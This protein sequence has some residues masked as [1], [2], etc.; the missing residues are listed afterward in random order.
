[1]KTSQ[2][3]FERGDHKWI[4]VA[5]DPAKPNYLIDTNEFVIRS[6]NEALLMDPGGTEIFPAVFSA[7]SHVM[8]PT[9]IKLLFASHQDPDIIS[10]L[11]LWIDFQPEIVCHLSWLWS[12]FVPHFGG[13]NETFAMIPDVGK[14]F[15]M[16]NIELEC[17][18][19]HYLHSSGNFH[20]YDKQAKILFSGDIGA[21]LLPADETNFVVTDFDKHIELARGFHQR[22]MGS[23]E[24]KNEWC[25]RVSN[26]DIDMMCPQHGAIYQGADVERFINWFADLP[27]GILNQN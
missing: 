2:I 20:L 7:I 11:A 27:V 12:S 4:M 16:N 5:R 18:P 22:W 6:G 8:D 9:E 1:M 13:T 19:A 10:S 17:V 26:M 25:E 15:R 21:A 14:K 23:N 3:I 24:A